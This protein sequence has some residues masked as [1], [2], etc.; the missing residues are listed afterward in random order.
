MLDNLTDYNR[1]RILDLLID[2]VE[3]YRSIGRDNFLPHYHLYIDILV[4]RK[5]SGFAL[6]E[7]VFEA[8]KQCI[9][10][11]EL[12]SEEIIN[13]NRF[14]DRTNS[15]SPILY[16][17]Y[18]ERGEA[19]LDELMPIVDKVRKDDLGMEDV[20][21]VIKE[22]E[23]Y[24]GL[25]I[26]FAVIQMAI[27]LSG[28]SFVN[29]AEGKVLLEKM[30]EAGDL[31]SHVPPALRGQSR[32]IA[33]ESAKYALRDGEAVD[34]QAIAPVLAGL[35]SESKATF[36]E[37]V[38]AIEAY[39]RNHTDKES[40]RQ[41]LYRYA[42][43]RDLLGEKV[44]RLGSADYYTLRLLEEIFRDKDCLASILVRAVDEIDQGLL[45]AEK[46]PL[47]HPEAMVKAIRKM[48]QG[49]G[50]RE[51]KV[52]RLAAM[53]T[54]Y[55]AADLN[56]K[57]VVNLDGNLKGVL[58]ELLQKENQVYVSKH[59]LAEEILS[60]P[61]AAIRKEKAKFELKPT[62][63]GINLTLRVVKGIPYSLWGLNAGVCIA[64]DVELWK[65]PNFK[66]ITMIDQESQ[67]TDGF[68]HVYEVMIRGR[69]YWTLPG[70]EPSTEF[71]GTVNP[72]ELYDKLIEQTI[73]FA[74]DAGIAGIYLPTNPNIH[75]N[76]SDIQKAIIKKDYPTKTI[77][78]V[79]WTKINDPQTGQEMY[80]FEEVFVVWENL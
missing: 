25:E 76:R 7:G 65:D 29:R 66:L 44:D 39:L 59:K 68:I 42:S 14:I 80:P 52:K 9:I 27:P 54:R 26:L 34:L 57:V 23:Q 53:T 15:F 49:S 11:K 67:T 8:T 24:D 40:L 31:R 75:S 69:K 37:L 17:L 22:Y 79:R 35:R 45:T 16:K 6:L 5:R 72:A 78:I 73:A 48:W 55:S 19:I 58:A 12:T 47:T 41:A 62:A 20:T 64:S 50:F 77:P 1:M 30:M 74:R 28:A 56:E 10:P 46:I 13:I 43:R 4:N 32:N 33:V 2:N 63:E 36:P 21:N 71:I 3:I 60:G 70:I 61:L 51:E 38:A 18:R